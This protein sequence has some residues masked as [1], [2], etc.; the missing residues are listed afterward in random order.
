VVKATKGQELLETP[1]STSLNLRSPILNAPM[2]GVAGGR[3]SAAISGAGGL[4]MIGA[5]TAGSVELIVR[6]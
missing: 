3:L 4:G 6:E 1:W 5:G 2:G